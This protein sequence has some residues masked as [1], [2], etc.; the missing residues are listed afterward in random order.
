MHR[1][2]RLSRG[3]RVLLALAVGG[4]IFGIATAV[5]A[6]IPDSGV[7]RGCY[8]KFNLHSLR[9]IDTSNGEHCLSSEVSLDWN[10]TGPP[11]SRVA[12]GAGS[13]F[14]YS[15]TFNTL[16]TVT[17]TAPAAGYVKV[18]GWTSFTPLSATS[19]EATVRLRDT[20][21][22]DVSHV[23]VTDFSGAGNRIM[24]LGWV[25][26]VPAAGTHT[27]A[28][29]FNSTVTSAPASPIVTALYVPEGA[30]G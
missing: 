14:I 29:E 1:L 27:Y 4:V 10:Q 20:G 19:G 17:I 11:A 21:T 3:G 23:E 25:F 15:L 16:A 2:R 22:G 7:I 6:D 8:A 24:S 26:S 9:V 28:L 18:D 13:D 30:N 5:Q 12:Q